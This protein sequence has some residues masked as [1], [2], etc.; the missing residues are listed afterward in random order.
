MKEHRFHQKVVEPYLLQF[1][2]QYRINILLTKNATRLGNEFVPAPPL[3]IRYRL[4]PAVLVIL[5]LYAENAV[6]S[7]AQIELK[8]HVE[9]APIFKIFACPPPA[10]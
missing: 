10:G 3:V 9:G 7:V 6:V 5:R 4:A 2:P 8:R 1:S